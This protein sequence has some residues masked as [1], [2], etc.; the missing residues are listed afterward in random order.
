MIIFPTE[1]PEAVVLVGVV[2]QVNEA[3]ERMSAFDWTIES[4]IDGMICKNVVLV[5]EAVAS[6]EQVEHHLS[7]CGLKFSNT[8]KN[9]ALRR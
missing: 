5:N 2:H 6:K 4:V 1:Q 7:M 3:V 9:F 8:R